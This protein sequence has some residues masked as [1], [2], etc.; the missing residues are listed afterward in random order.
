MLRKR[1]AANKITRGKILC[2]EVK[3]R[4]TGA[5]TGVG[6]DMCVCEIQPSTGHQLA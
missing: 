5:F 4:I 3:R 1:N 2:A 6:G